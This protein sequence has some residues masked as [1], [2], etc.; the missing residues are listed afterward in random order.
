[1]GEFAWKCLRLGIGDGIAGAADVAHDHMSER[2]IGGLLVYVEVGAHQA[3]DPPARGGAGDG[4]VD[5]QQAGLLAHVDLPAQP[6]ERE[7]LAHEE[8]IAEMPGALGSSEPLALLKIASIALPPRLGISSS[9]VPLP[10]C[11]GRSR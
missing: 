10:P 4:S 7:S 3:T 2:M 6:C 1:M 8:A 5:A 11:F 9:T